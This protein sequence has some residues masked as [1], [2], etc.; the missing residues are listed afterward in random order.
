LPF[1]TLPLLTRDFHS[2]QEK[3][4][5]LQGLYLFLEKQDVLL[6]IANDDIFFLL[7]YL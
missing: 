4:F 3:E 6:V 1:N 5:A 7:L 2:A